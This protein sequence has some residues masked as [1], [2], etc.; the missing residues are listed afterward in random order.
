[1]NRLNR[2]LANILVGALVLVPPILIV[3]ATNGFALVLLLGLVFLWLV[4]DTIIDIL[5]GRDDDHA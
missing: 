3:I 1:M 5:S 2:F 4:G